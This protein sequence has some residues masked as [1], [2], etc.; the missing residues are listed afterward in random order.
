MSESDEEWQP[1]GG[2]GHF[3]KISNKDVT[4]IKSNHSKNKLNETIGDKPIL[5]DSKNSNYLYNLS[6]QVLRIEYPGLVKDV[7]A[8]IDTL[9]KMHEIEMVINIII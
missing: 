7:S 2:T 1:D 9:G 3:L 6:K 8:A 4:K 5:H